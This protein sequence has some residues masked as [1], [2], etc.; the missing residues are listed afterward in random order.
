VFPNNI[1]QRIYQHK[2]KLVEGFT[3]KYNI[4]KLVYYEKS[5]SIISAIK[6]G[7]QI[8]GKVRM[9]KS[10]LIKDF[11]PEWNDLYETIL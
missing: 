10:C 4:N 2:N 3:K 7:K 5:E 1:P 6:R 11:N 8:K 9:Y